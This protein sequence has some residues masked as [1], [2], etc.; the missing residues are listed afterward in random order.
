MTA[1]EEVVEVVGAGGQL[2]GEKASPGTLE[3]KVTRPAGLDGVPADT[4]VTVAVTVVG[5]RTVVGFGERTTA[6]V[7]LRRFTARRTAGEEDEA[8][9]MLVPGNAAVSG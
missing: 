4:S 1:Q 3:E 7:V 6:V 2:A 9:W 5:A 8:A